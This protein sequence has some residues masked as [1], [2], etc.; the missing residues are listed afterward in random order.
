MVG[1]APASSSCARSRTLRALNNMRLKKAANG[2]PSAA[3]LSG[4]NDSTLS[5]QNTNTSARQAYILIL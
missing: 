3:M 2:G 1:D 4:S 5:K